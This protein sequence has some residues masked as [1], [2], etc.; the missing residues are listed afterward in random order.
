MTDLN[1]A[2]IYM[3]TLIGDIFLWD[4]WHTIYIHIYSSTMDPMGFFILNDIF[5]LQDGAPL[6]EMLMYHPP[7]LVR[8]PSPSEK[9]EKTE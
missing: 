1:G 8:E 4:P 6:Y 5:Y 3:L 2:G 7:E 9:R